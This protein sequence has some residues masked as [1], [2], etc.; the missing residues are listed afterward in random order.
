MN[1]DEK[2]NKTTI[3]IKEKTVD[4]DYFCYCCDRLTRE[5]CELIKS[6]RGQLPCED[7]GK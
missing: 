7:D 5:N 4:T 1:A 3:V 6:L 2:N